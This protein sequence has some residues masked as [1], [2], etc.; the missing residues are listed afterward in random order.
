M[1]RSS[2]ELQVAHPHTAPYLKSDQVCH[3]DSSNQL[4]IETI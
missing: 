1:G 4:T 3:S 2:P